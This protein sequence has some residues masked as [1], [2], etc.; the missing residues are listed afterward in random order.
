MKTAPHLQ[1]LVA[2]TAQ[3]LFDKVT[4]LAPQASSLMAKSIHRSEFIMTEIEKAQQAVLLVEHA[5]FNVKFAAEE[6]RK[7]THAK[8]IDQFYAEALDRLDVKLTGA[9]AYLTRIEITGR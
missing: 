8:H 9:R 7:I 6:E 2:Q 4:K 5:I 3:P 1:L